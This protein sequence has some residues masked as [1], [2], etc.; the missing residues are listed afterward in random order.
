MNM[1]NKESVNSYA[2]DPKIDSIRA[3]GTLWIV[4]FYHLIGYTNCDFSFPQSPF[5]TRAILASF[6]FVS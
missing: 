2:R 4:G 3:L 5:I 1:F 6:V